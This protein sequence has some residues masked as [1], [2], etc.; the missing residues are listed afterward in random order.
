MDLHFFTQYTRSWSV[1]PSGVTPEFTRFSGC[2]VN[3]K[4]MIEAEVAVVR[5]AWVMSWC[6]PLS[7][8]HWRSSVP[9]CVLTSR[10]KS[11]SRNVSVL[12]RGRRCSSSC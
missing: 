3:I 4:S 11:P 12:S 7:P 6:S 2:D 9:L 1:I 10:L 8:V 5:V